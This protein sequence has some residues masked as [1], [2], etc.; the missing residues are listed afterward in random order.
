MLST[1]R[2]KLIEFKSTKSPHSILISRPLEPQS[3]EEELQSEVGLISVVVQVQ[4]GV[5]GLEGLLEM[6]PE[7][8]LEVGV[9]DDVHSVV[10]LAL[11]LLNQLHDGAELELTRNGVSGRH[12]MIKIDV[13]DEWLNLYPLLNLRL[14]HVFVDLS[15]VPVDA[16]HQT[17][18]VSSGL[19]SL[20]VGADDDGLASSKSAF[21]EDDDSSVLQD[22][23]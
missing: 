17:V 18:R 20:L 23:A 19:G 10:A 2:T 9:L 7:D 22:L 13:F 21:E 15:G 12:D 14:G 11:L 3:L 5:L 16:G 4:P 6:L 1:L 8:G